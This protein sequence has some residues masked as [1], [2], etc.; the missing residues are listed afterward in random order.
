MLATKMFWGKDTE[1]AMVG[2]VTAPMMLVSLTVCVVNTVQDAVRAVVCSAGEEL[3][4]TP[5][6]AHV[7][8]WVEARIAVTSPADA[9]LP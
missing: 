8:V 1:D 5:D 7:C 6:V 3:E 9:R 4:T 2:L